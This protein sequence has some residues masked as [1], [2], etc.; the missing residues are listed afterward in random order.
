MNFSNAQYP[1]D[2][3]TCQTTMGENRSGFDGRLG[4]E[5]EE[6]LVKLRSE[7]KGREPNVSGT[8]SMN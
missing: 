7:C 5:V 4:V 3:K 2:C 8:T 1:V 6:V